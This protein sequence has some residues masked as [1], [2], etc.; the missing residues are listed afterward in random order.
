MPYTSLKLPFTPGSTLLGTE[1][2]Q[3]AAESMHVSASSIRGRILEWAHSRLVGITCD[4]V[5]HAL[6]YRHQTA[7]AR[8]KE[9]VDSGALRE[10]GDTRTTR[11]G[12]MAR[13]LVHRD[14][15]TKEESCQR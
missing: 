7:S 13:V 3:A 12:R 10:R 8:I 9:L 15:A 6:G 5:E 1:A 11:S 14:Y 4:E 2:S